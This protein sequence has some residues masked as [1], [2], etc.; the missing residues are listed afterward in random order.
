MEYIIENKGRIY[1]STTEHE[2]WKVFD[3]ILK[4][5]KKIVLPQFLIGR[6]PVYKYYNYEDDFCPIG[7][8]IQEMTGT[9]CSIFQTIDDKVL[10]RRVQRKKV[11]LFS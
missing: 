2:E 10:L 4:D 11:A 7:D 1:L 3:P 6:E 5:K 9:Y 8:D